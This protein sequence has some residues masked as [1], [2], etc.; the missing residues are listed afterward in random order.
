MQFDRIER[1]LYYQM[2]ILNS[3]RD[4]RRSLNPAISRKTSKLCLKF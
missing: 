1:K 3:E 2:D 4:I